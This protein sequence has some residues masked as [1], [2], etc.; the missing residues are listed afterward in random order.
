MKQRIIIAGPTAS[1]KSDLSIALAKHIGG[2]I[3]SVDS[4]QCYKLID[5]GTAKPTPEQLAEVPHH[6]ISVLDLNE[7][8]NV[9]GFRKRAEA[10][11]NEIE[12][13]GN[14]VIYCGGS[15]LHLQSL[16]KPLDD[17]P[18]S[19]ADNITRLKQIDKREGIETL[20]RQLQECDPE[21][22]ASMDGMNRQ[23]IYRALDVWI[24]T[25]KPFSS[26]HSNRETTLPPDFHF[27]ALHHPRK[28][29]HVRINRRTERMIE[30][31]LVQETQS[32][33]EKGYRPDLQ[34]LQTVGYRQV[35]DYLNGITDHEQ[36]VKDIKTAT[37]RYAKRQITWLRRW[38]FVHTIDMSITSTEK[39]VQTIEHQVAAEA[40]KG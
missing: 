17:I 34:A 20:Y 21:Y 5:I 11:A 1:G 39:A 25:G 26:F 19:N 30:I 7:E 2:E 28:A 37:R 27:F 24:Q 29:L 6:N 31:G 3:I 15:T 36:M 4:R 33:L 32:I 35:I 10:W 38:S 12:S 40:Q 13:R 16:I 23:R 9:A 22:A 8:D 14:R 18:S